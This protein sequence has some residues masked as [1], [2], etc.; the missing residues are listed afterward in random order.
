L[1]VAVSST[2]CGRQDSEIQ[3]HREALQS[4]NATTQALIAAWLDGHVSGTYT[5]VALQHT[6]R[7]VEQQRAALASR[8]EALIDPRGAEVAN[9]A[10]NVE[11]TL[12]A[13]LQAVH[14][15]DGMAARTH[16]ADIPVRT[17]AERP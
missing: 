13:L 7:L 14:R 12:A 4:L 5:Q 16:L 11:R 8:P 17:A 3:Q 6:F 15:A 1:A 2:V 9:A 10:D